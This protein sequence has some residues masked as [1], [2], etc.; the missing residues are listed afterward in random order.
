VT[1]AVRIGIGLLLL[2]AAAGIAWLTSYMRRDMG[3]AMEGTPLSLP[4]RVG[5]FLCLVAG[6]LVLLGASL[7]WWIWVG[8]VLASAVGLRIF[9][10]KYQG[11]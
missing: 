7:D 11:F 9:I 5:G 4:F 8:A 3:S 1:T 2:A 10:F 6:I